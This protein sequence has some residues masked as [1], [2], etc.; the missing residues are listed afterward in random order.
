MNISEKD[1]EIMLNEVNFSEVYKKKSK[2][3]LEL[4]NNCI[5]NMSYEEAMEIL[6]VSKKYEEF[7]EIDDKKITEVVKVIVRYVN[8]FYATFSEFRCSD[9]GVERNY[10]FY[11]NR[12]NYYSTI[13]EELNSEDFN[14]SKIKTMLVFEKIFVDYQELSDCSGLSEINNYMRNNMYSIISKYASLIVKDSL[15]LRDYYLYD[16]G[17]KNS[18]KKYR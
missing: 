12:V 6:R 4:I 17:S 2:S 16:K 18:R 11:N 10:E 8:K 5:D 7:S 3:I 13:I 15:K 9:V 14:F 1:K